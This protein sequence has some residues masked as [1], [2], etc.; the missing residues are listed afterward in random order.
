MRIELLDGYFIDVD[1]LNYTLKQ[2]YTSK[3][4]DGQIKTSE[5]TVG[6]Y[7]SLRNAI[8]HF[9]KDVQNKDNATLQIKDYAERIEEANKTLASALEEL[10]KRIQA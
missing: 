6:Y 4:K 1:S 8:E 10:W 2:I 3:T 9:L 5:R 7:G